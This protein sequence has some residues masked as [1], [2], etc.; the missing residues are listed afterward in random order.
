MKI[1]LLAGVLATLVLPGEIPDLPVAAILALTGA[2]SIEELDESELE[3]YYGLMNHPLDLNSA[4]E[5]RLRASGLFN[6]LQLQSL[7]RER[8][9]RGDILSYTELSL[10]SGFG[11]D[12][13]EALR[14][15]TRLSSAGAGSAAE[16]GFHADVSAKIQ[17]RRD[18]PSSNEALAEGARLKLEY[19][20]IAEF[21]WTGRN[22]YSSPAFGPGTF[23]AAWYPRR[24]NAKIVAGHYSA[25]F[26]QGLLSW[27]GFSLSSIASPASLVRNGSGI[28]PTSSATADN[29]GLAGDLSLGRWQFSAG[30]DFSKGFRPMVNLS[31]HSD[32]ASLGVSASK[33]GA[34]MDW[35]LA[36]R[37]ISLFGEAAFRKGPAVSS[38]LM[39]VPS[40]GSRLAFRASWFSPAYGNSYSGAALSYGNDWLTAGA[41][42]GVKLRDGTQQYSAL[43]QLGK[44]FHARAW[45]IRPS[46]RLKGRYRSSSTPWRCELR[47]DLEIMR[48][49][50][51]TSLRYDRLWSAASSWLFY[52]GESLDLG[53][54]SLHTRFSL[55]CVDDWEDRIYSYER[56]LPWSFSV[57]AYY[58]RGY[59]V[60]AVFSLKPGRGHR[61]DFKASWTDYP[62]NPQP[63]DS[64]LDLRAQYSFRF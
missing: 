46:L 49:C 39:W 36:F 40:Y 37:N 47:G 61:F 58:G 56:D 3:I 9:L 51:T 17:W 55:F 11:P 19:A 45:I 21:R 8:R 41:E 59:S 28:A 15:F 52:A 14:P 64:R 54:F 43:L 16:K 29:L 12:F 10:I 50:S 18:Q 60:Y 5:S 20:D 4:G 33:E 38:G 27:S 32:R 25:R 62:W 2:F 44:A 6:E 26:G 13:A 48:G 35:R 34:S 1:F 30:L 7:L 22:T 42:G 31:R 23:S 57:P 63:K 24:A 53:V